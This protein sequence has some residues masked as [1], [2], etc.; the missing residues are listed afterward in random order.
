MTHMDM[1][2]H[3]QGKPATCRLWQLTSVYNLKYRIHRIMI[4]W[5]DHT[6]MSSCTATPARDVLL[7]K[8]AKRYS[9]LPW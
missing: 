1:N 9:H 3:V 5:H 7:E 6:I 2:E 4:D 8:A